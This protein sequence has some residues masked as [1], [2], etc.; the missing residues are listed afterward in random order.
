MKKQISSFLVITL[1]A[2]GSNS[3][4]GPGKN[5]VAD[6]S[7]T[8]KAADKP[9]GPGCTSF[10]WFKKGTV[11]EY[12]LTGADGTPQ[13]NSTTTIN[14][15]KQD[16][17]AMIADYTTSLGAGKDIK[18]SY[19]CEGDKIYMDMKSFFQNNFSGLQ[20]AGME[21]EVKNGYVSFPSDMKVGENLDGATFEVDAKKNGKDFMKIIS[22]V[23]ERKVEATE[24]ITTPGGTWN[25]L[26]LSEVRTTTSEV[27][28][29]KV[30]GAET[31]SLQ[32]FAPGIGPVK[33]EMYDGNGH[34]TSRSELISIK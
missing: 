32:W 26:R 11:L 24:K 18:G 6:S 15:V 19:R 8:I 16:G 13:G 27:M 23:K 33:F 21:M 12:R 9:D 20:K 28:G 7:V 4:N 10:L 17:G 34:L 5:G 2:C 3:T 29:R 22:E 30:P 25:C 31:K 14:D 1:I